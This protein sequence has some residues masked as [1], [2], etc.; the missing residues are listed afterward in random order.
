MTFDRE[1]IDAI[2]NNIFPLPKE[3]GSVNYD[4]EFEVINENILRQ[5]IFEVD[6]FA[7]ICYGAS[8]L[9]II[10]PKIK[11]IV[12]K[13]PFNGTYYSIEE[14]G[15]IVWEPFHWAPGSDNTD[16]CLAEYE[17]Y[18][19]LK[20]YGLDCFVAKT[21]YYK[22][23]D[24]VRIFLQEKV[25]LNSESCYSNAFPS[26]KSKSIAQNWWAEGVICIDPE[27]IASCLDK[28]GKSKVERF[29]WYCNNIDLDILEDAYSSNIGYRENGTPVIADYSN[30]LE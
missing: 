15:S 22:T 1:K 29:L 25:I 6:P 11:N 30:F 7:Y 9:V 3:F 28:Y 12:I 14:D 8:K 10:S 18:C 13:I 2:L 19:R 4:Y 24:N 5:A 27:W 26:E 20:T 17:K 21:C 23:I 16:Y